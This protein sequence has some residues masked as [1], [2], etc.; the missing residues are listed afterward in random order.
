[1]FL[2]PNLPS[3]L[4]PVD[5][6]IGHSVKSHFRRLLVRHIL[7]KIHEEMTKELSQRATFNIRQTVTKYDMVWLMT[8]AWD[9]VTDTLI[10]NRWLK[11]D[12]LP[13]C[14]EMKVRS[15]HNASHGNVSCAIRS[16]SAKANDSVILENRSKYEDAKIK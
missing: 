15:L 16:P 14:L 8:E 2:P 13:P 1:M 4:Q 11:S 12:I 7:Q 6:S 5:A 10:L 3:H 9:L